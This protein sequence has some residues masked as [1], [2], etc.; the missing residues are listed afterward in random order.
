MK[1]PLLLVIMLLAIFVM[2]V[3]I[4]ALASREEISTGCCSFLPSYMLIPI[5]AST[6]LFVGSAVYYY[7]SDYQKSNGDVK[8]DVSPLLRFLD[9]E[10][11]TVIEELVKNKGSLTQSGIVRGTG[12]NK[13]KVSRMLGDFEQRGLIK[14]RAEG[15]SNVIELEEKLKELLVG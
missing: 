13:V 7:L 2:I 5:L 14:K 11:R 6:G 12:L 3:S 15:I 8:K 1:N 4:A 9:N 10:E